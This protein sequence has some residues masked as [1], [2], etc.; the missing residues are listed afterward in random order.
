M[1]VKR[2]LQRFGEFQRWLEL[3]GKELRKR[4]ELEKTYLKSQIS[5]LKLYSRWAKPYLKAAAQ[6]EQRAT[7]TSSL[8]STFSTSLF[9]LTL[10]GIGDYVGMLTYMQRRYGVAL[11][12]RLDN[13]S[14]ANGI[15]E[16]GKL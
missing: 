13:N 6:L 7:A 1:I 3:S 15:K 9:E 4:Y 11:D 10:L 5:S 16:I 14:K 2:L 8:V 12:G